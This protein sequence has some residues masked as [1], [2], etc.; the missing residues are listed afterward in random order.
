MEGRQETRQLRHMER[1]T[2]MAMHAAPSPSISESRRHAPARATHLASHLALSMPPR[3]RTVA[4]LPLPS[5][6]QGTTAAQQECG[7]GSRLDC[8]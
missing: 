6:M 3:E 8:P 7:G 2:C 4:P 1:P 5:L